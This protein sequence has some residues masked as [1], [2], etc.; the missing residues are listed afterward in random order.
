MHEDEHG[1]AQV[2]VSGCLP[3]TALRHSQRVTLNNRPRT[4]RHRS[5]GSIQH[6]LARRNLLNNSRVHHTWLPRGN[7]TERPA[8]HT[9]SA[10]EADGQTTRVFK[11]RQ[12]VCIQLE[13]G[14]AARMKAWQ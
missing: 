3:R 9:T 10:A 7:A 13:L 5:V 12:V 6:S 2:G 11:G 1:P 8:L 14:L 4:L